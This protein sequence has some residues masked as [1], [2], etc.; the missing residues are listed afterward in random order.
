VFFAEEKLF[1]FG[2]LV[3]SKHADG[4]VEK[5]KIV[6]Q[7]KIPCTVKFEIK[8]KNPASNDQLAFKLI[9]KNEVKIPPHEHTYVKVQFNPTIMAVY[10]GVFEAIVVNGEQNPRTSKLVFDLRG[11]GAL[12]TIKIEKPKDFFD[13]RTP[14]LKFQKTRVNRLLSAPIILKN[15]G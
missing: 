8:K 3:Y 10:S 7:N 2:T 11:E 4:I 6:N 5:F 13:E 9:S 12:P 15:D 14:L 1:N